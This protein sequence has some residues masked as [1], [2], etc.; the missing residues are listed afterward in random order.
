MFYGLLWWLWFVLYS[1]FWYCVMYRSIDLVFLVS[2]SVFMFAVFSVMHHKWISCGIIKLF[3]LNS[4]QFNAIQW[5]GI[6][7]NWFQVWLFHMKWKVCDKWFQWTQIKVNF[8][9][10]GLWS[11]EISLWLEKCIYIYIH[12][13][14][15]MKIQLLKEA[16]CKKFQNNVYLKC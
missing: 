15:W 2:C 13:F 5:N 7:L 9:I 12:V 4:I 14:C 6:E 8:K 3:E 16:S 10:F 1:N 11:L